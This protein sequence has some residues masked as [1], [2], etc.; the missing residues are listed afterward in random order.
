MDLGGWR[1]IHRACQKNVVSKRGDPGR[2]LQYCETFVSNE[3]QRCLKL[4]DVR[5]G[6]LSEQEEVGKQLPDGRSHRLDETYFSHLWTK[7][8]SDTKP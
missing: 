1:P 7:E 4:A 6:G 5:V 8:G 3:Q 2:T